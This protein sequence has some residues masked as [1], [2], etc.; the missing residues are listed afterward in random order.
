MT[1]RT[2][3]IVSAILSALA[4][5]TSTYGWQT[6]TTIAVGGGI[7]TVIGVI[8]YQFWKGQSDA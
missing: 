6:D 8:G 1:N 5:I 4:G 3:N 2:G 7:L